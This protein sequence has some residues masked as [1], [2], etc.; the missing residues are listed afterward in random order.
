MGSVEQA[1]AGLR[2]LTGST[3]GVSSPPLHYGS[4]ATGTLGLEQRVSGISHPRS[5]ARGC[6]MHWGPRS[7]SHSPSWKRVWEQHPPPTPGSLVQHL[8]S[9][10]LGVHWVLKCGQQPKDTLALAWKPCGRTAYLS[11]CCPVSHVNSQKHSG[12]LRRSGVRAS[13]CPHLPPL[14][15]RSDSWT[16][17]TLPAQSLPSGE[18]CQGAPT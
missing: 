8:G 3:L 12:G 17:H 7:P 4:A 16:S 15:P 5:P 9:F 2:G 1:R 6:A 18:L 10:L 14:E 11:R 13:L